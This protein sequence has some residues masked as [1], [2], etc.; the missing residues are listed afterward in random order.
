VENWQRLLKSYLAGRA[1]LRRAFVLIDARHGIK[2]VDEEI[3]NLL[4]ISAVVFQIVLT[5]AD[6]AKEKDRDNL[7]RRVRGALQAH[8]AAFPEIVLTSSETG[9]GVEV[10]RA[11][12]SGSA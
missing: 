11:I 6:K 5:K 1:T 7:L 4:D 12:I 2:P 10:L 3:L 9:E 8:P